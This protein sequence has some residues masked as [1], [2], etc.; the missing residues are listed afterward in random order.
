MTPILVPAEIFRD[1][2]VS[3][4][5]VFMNDTSQERFISVFQFQLALYMFLRTEVVV[6]IRRNDSVNW[7]SNHCHVGK[8]LNAIYSEIDEIKVPRIDKF[9]F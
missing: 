6:Q 7:V 3:T 4:A 8:V 2:I 5:L 1:K 9:P